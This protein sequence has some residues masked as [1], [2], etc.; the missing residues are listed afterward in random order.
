MLGQGQD[1]AQLGEMRATGGVPSLVNE[2]AIVSVFRQHPSVFF[3]GGVWDVAYAGIVDLEPAIVE[4]V[5]AR[6]RAIYLN[7]L[8]DCVAFLRYRAPEAIITHRARNSV[9]FLSQKLA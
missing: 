9:D 3:D 1:I 4:E 2:D 5:Q 6:F 7:C 8:E